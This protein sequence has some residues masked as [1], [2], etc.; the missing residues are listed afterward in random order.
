VY[1]AS[2]QRSDYKPSKALTINLPKEMNVPE[3]V[4]QRHTDGSYYFLINASMQNDTRPKT[5]SDRIGIIWDNSLS[6]LSRDHEKELVLLDKIIR[7]KQHLVIELGLLNTGFKHAGSFVVK[8]GDWSALKHFLQNL[9]YDGGTNFGQVDE[10]VLT[11]DEYLLFSDGLSTFG[12]QNIRI[13][14]PVYSI[15][16]VLKS[17]FGTLK[18]VSSRTG[19]KFINLNH[20]SVDDAFQQIRSEGLQFLGIAEQATVSEVYPSSPVE[21]NGHIAVAGKIRASTGEVT[22]LFGRNGQVESRQRV[23][24][25]AENSDIQAGRI[26][27]QMKIAE[28]DVRYED[29]K[30][31]IELLGR[32]FGIVTRNTSL[33]V[34][35]EVSDYV[36][37]D[38]VPPD[39]LLSEYK[40]LLQEKQLQKENRVNDLLERAIA[41]TDDLKA[42][43]NTDFSKKNGKQEYVIEE[44]MSEYVL[45]EE[46]IPFTEQ[47]ADS[48]SQDSDYRMPAEDAKEATD[49]QSGK[50]QAG[51][52]ASIH[53]PPIKSDKDYIRQIRSAT[54]PYSEYLTLRETYM[55]TPGFY[56]DVSDFFYEIQQAETGFLILSC[57]AELDI[58]NAE[59]FK[60]LAYKLNER[61]RYHDELFIT[62]KIRE[63]R[64]MDPQSHR[65]YALSLQKNGQYQEALE[66]LY[67]ILNASYSQEAANRDQGI[68]EVIVCEINNLISRHKK[69]LDLQAIHPQIIADLPVDIRV[70]I[71]WNK[72]HT[73]IDLWVTDPNGIKCFYHHPRTSSGGRISNDFTQGF[74]PEQFMLKTAGNGTYKVETNFYGEQQ[75]TLSGPTA[76]MAEIYLYYSDGRQ[77]RQTVT[78]QSGENGREEEGVLIATFEFSDNRL[79][80]SPLR[81]P[82]PVYFLAGVICFGLFL[83]VYYRKK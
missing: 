66:C 53:L 40:R 44:E 18:A 52:K 74:G 2:L 15:C 28:M 6:G 5:W 67:G 55:G 62:R 8:D 73:D 9:V 22:L 42:W 37:Y 47:V 1:E 48:R 7:Q 72:N 49:S 3:A 20:T 21:V 68:E 69:E 78:F 14:K 75:L 79:S 51:S 43:W 56:F 50:S 29:N 64:P 35:E 33:L 10:N 63:W 58:E 19:G 41:M 54:D 24:L 34:L 16:S 32:Q 65:D 71:N 30:E 31:A 81:I 23:N 46:E 27:A 26:W 45:E 4:M 76:I 36:R 70:V 39:E 59:L 38:I 82:A 17:D 60:T 11:V 61:G 83:F 57:L 12:A 80:S 25:R 13:D 77:E